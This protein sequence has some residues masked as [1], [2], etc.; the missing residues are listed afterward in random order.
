MSWY[1]WNT[2]LETERGNLYFGKKEAHSRKTDG[3]MA[4]VSAI[5]AADDLTDSAESNSYDD[6][7]V[8]SY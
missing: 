2:S 5:C 8:Y 6:F 4:L 7:C 1:T 3:F